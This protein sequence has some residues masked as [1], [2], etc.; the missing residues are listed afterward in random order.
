M[1][2][3]V[4][5]GL[6]SSVVAGGAAA[7]DVNLTGYW[8]GTY[9]CGQGLTGVNLTI[10]KGFGSAFDAVFHFYAVPQNPGVPTGCF[11][12]WGRIEPYT[13]QFSLKS[14]DGQWIIRPPEYTVANANGTVSPDGRSMSGKIEAEGCSNIELQRI[15]KPPLAPAKCAD[16]L[17][18]AAAPSDGSV[19]GR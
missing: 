6:L 15:D 1:K 13:R 9:K 19:A 3:V 14:D 12:M 10:R 16:A 18:L 17:P 5:A 11:K 4:L 8:R 2:R 7:Q